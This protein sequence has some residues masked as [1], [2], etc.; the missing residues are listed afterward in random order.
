MSTVDHTLY[1]VFFGAAL[2]SWFTYESMGQCTAQV[3]TILSEGSIQET[4]TAIRITG[5][6]DT[7]IV[8]RNPVAGLLSSGGHSA[9][10]NVDQ[11]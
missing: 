5:Q 10:L 3:R 4:I 7:Q 11:G 8:I 2:R 6:V 1:D 9:S